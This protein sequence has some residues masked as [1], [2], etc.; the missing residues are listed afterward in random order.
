MGFVVTRASNRTK[1]T[2]KDILLAVK[3][4]GEIHG[5]Y[6]IKH[7]F[8]I[9]RNNTA[10]PKATRG[11]KLGAI[12]RKMCCSGFRKQLWQQLT[13]QE[14]TPT[15]LSTQTEYSDDAILMAL[16]TYREK[17]GDCI[18]KH[19]FKIAENDNT[20]PETT[21]GMQLGRVVFNMRYNG[22]RTT[23]WEQI[24]SL[25]LTTSSVKRPHKTLVN[26]THFD[27]E[28]QRI[29]TEPFHLFSQIHTQLSI[30]HSFVIPS[31]TEWPQQYHGLQLGRLAQD[32]RHNLAIN[33]NYYNQNDVDILQKMGH[34]GRRARNTS[35]D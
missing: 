25:G 4:Y 21:R 9:N 33:A 30:P 12:V 28:Q 8:K 13:S 26:N 24:V 14:M 2:D 15:P 34:L 18:V 20:W 11:M 32:I 1:H 17:Y 6:E 23:L 3:T 7:K 31:T 27:N 5:D 16:H 29:D 19:K 10:W 35:L 22:K